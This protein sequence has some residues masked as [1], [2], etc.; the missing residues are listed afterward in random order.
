[1]KPQDFL[2]PDQIKTDTQSLKTYGADWTKHYTPDP[3]IILFPKTTKDV[4]NIV[5]WARATKTSLVP[6]GGRTGLSA[7][8]FATNKEAVISFERMNT[9]LEFNPIDSTVTCEPGVIT[10]A[11]QNYAKDKN[12]I[13]PVDFAATGSSQIGGNVSTNAG[14][15]K[16]IKYGLTRDWIT[17]LEVVTG[18]GE[19]LTLNNSLVKNASGY[20]LKHLFI[21]SEGTLGFIT[22]VT[23]KLCPPPKETQ[24]L[25][26]SLEK[27][28]DILK[29]YSLF[30]QKHS[31]L[32]F[33]YISKL[34]AQKVVA[35]TKYN[36]P[37]QDEASHYLLIELEDTTENIEATFS[38]A[39]ENEWLT[40]GVISQNSQQTQEI[41]AIRENI[42]ETLSTEHPY[43]NDVSV[44]ISKVTEFLEQTDKLLK[45]DYPNIEVVWFGHIGDGNMHINILKPAD[46]DSEA[47]LKQCHKVDDKLFSIIESLGGSISAEHGVGLVKKDYLK[48]TR[49]EAEISLMKQIKTVFDPDGIMNP[50]KMF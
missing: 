42:S 43:K 40:D 35:A 11:L 8:A 18:S 36:L 26:L 4:V 45:A 20:D 14:G 50:G 5:N 2:Q 17:S 37:V 34:A 29:V 49:S 13:F 21:G 38:T 32:A 19:V 33:E 23:V 16:V 10:E 22:K 41:W 7:A 28:E 12:L 1:M 44:K 25:F 15:I 24:V 9:V 39:F 47:F 27:L 48:Y 46:M 6:S 30:T 31:V 3:S